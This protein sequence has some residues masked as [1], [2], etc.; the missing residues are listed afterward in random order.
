MA[1]AGNNGNN[2]DNSNSVNGDC[3]GNNIGSE[4]LNISAAS[5]SIIATI[6]AVYLTSKLSIDELETLASF[7]STL[8]SLLFLNIDQMGGNAIPAGA[9]TGQ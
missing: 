9:I 1:S 5:L 4:N 8:S 3:D 6:I 2:G 7:L